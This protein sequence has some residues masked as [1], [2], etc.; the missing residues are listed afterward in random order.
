MLPGSA[1]Q[2]GE[3]FTKYRDRGG[4]SPKENASG[5]HKAQACLVY[6]KLGREADKTDLGEQPGGGGQR[7]VFLASTPVLCEYSLLPICIATPPRHVLTSHPGGDA[8]DGGWA[9]SSLPWLL[10][11]PPPHPTPSTPA[12]N[13]HLILTVQ[14]PG[15][16][17]EDQPQRWQ[18]SGCYTE[19]RKKRAG[20]E[21]R[22]DLGKQGE[23]LHE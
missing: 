21:R 6:A 16:R 2:L 8:P 5:T 12:G 13:S 23:M 15:D 18:D 1:L 17:A 22:K 10:P 3:W 9:L 19:L 7:S 20:G 4:A 14:T 11:A